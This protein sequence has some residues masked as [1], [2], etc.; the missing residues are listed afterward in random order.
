MGEFV[1]C[2]LNYFTRVVV[3]GL[4]VFFSGA[5]QA[6]TRARLTDVDVELQV[7]STGESE[8][9]TSARFEVSGGQFHGFDLAPQAT[10]TLV[11][12]KCFARIEGGLRTHVKIKTL[13]DGRQRVVMAN[14][15]SINEGAVVFTLV[16]ETNLQET[17]AL[18]FHNGRARLDW[19]PIVWDHGTDSMSVQVH[20]PGPGK[21]I[22]F[23]NDAMRDY[24]VEVLTP[25][26]VK[27]RK[28]RTVKW[29]PMQVV[30]DFDAHLVALKK[31]PSV[32]NTAASTAQ[33]DHKVAPRV[34]SESAQ[35][36]SA[37]PAP[38]YSRLIPA[39]IAL[40]GLF[41]MVWKVRT[42]QRAHRDVGILV[43]FRLLRHT[44]LTQRL[45]L[46]IVAIAVGLAAQLA[47]SVAAS[48]PPLA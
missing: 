5:A 29:Y 46:S 45:M 21:E 6:W 33:R 7:Q 1:T 16:H 11:K 34:E 3:V 48:V 18:Q 9:T 19:T 17:G 26:T 22:D 13:F 10:R 40:M 36:D 24:E 2:L 32:Q 27:F 47:G 43:N 23:E 31:Q 12:E 38:A 28:F 42:V 39:I 30:M 35:L 20:L 14:R 37:A 8:F 4:I 15:E 41:L 44:R 25:D